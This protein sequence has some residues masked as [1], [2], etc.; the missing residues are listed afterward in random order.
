MKKVAFARPKAAEAATADDWVRKARPEAPEA[1]SE[2]MKRFTLDVP[3]SLHR[4]IKMQ[5]AARGI[6]MADAIRALLERE[7][8]A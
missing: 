5:C 4:R 8:P 1:E 2:P 3:E 6:K 7:F